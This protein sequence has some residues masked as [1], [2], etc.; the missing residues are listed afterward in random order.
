M[1]SVGGGFLSQIV[2]HLETPW[3]GS[4]SPIVMDCPGEEVHEFTLRVARHPNLCGG[5]G[6][7]G[8]ANQGA[9]WRRYVARPE[10][11]GSL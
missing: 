7:G 5:F 9:H 3:G 1:D 6:E 4:V 2:G 11:G 8:E 10:S